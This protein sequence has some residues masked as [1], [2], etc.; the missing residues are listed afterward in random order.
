MSHEPSVRPLRAGEWRTYRDL[1]LKALADSPDAF[2]AT[3]ANEESRTDADWANRL[4]SGADHRWNLPLVAEVAAQPIGLAWGRIE[5]TNPDVAKV[6]QMWVAPTHRGTGA[7][8]LLVEAIVAWAKAAGVSRVAL[9][10]TCGDSSA[11]RLYSRVGFAP[12]RQPEPLRPGS[13]LF[14]QP[15]ELRLP[16]E[17]P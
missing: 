1:R 17:A 3:L 10:V 9:S 14:A 6:Y 13:R 8:R 4:A 7:G 12:V 16:N 15:M 11:K 5:P 2:G